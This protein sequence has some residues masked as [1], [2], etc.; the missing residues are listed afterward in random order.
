[1]GLC[2]LPRD[3]DLLPGPFRPLACVLSFTSLFLASFQG[4]LP[5]DARLR[6]SPFPSDN[7]RVLFLSPSSRSARGWFILVTWFWSRVL[8]LLRLAPRT[9]L[10]SFDALLWVR[11]GVVRKVLGP[12]HCLTHCHAAE[13]KP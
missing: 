4:L 2:S 11:Q 12:V 10:G 9:P 8:T 7:P 13:A 5:F 3:S 6:A 1:M